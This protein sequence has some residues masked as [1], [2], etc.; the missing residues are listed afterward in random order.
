MKEFNINDK[1]KMYLDLKN[2]IS[3]LTEQQQIIRKEIEEYFRSQGIDSLKTDLGSV[4]YISKEY[5]SINK[6]LFNKMLSDEIKEQLIEKKSSK[7]IAIRENI[8]KERIKE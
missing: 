5:E 4:S 2:D 7:Y 3:A 1:M 8:K 6:E